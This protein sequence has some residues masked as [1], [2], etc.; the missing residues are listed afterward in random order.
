[1]DFFSYKLQK[2]NLVSYLIREQK[3]SLEEGSE[4]RLKYVF[5]AGNE[6]A[7]KSFKA[8]IFKKCG[9]KKHKNFSNSAPIYSMKIDL[10]ID[11]NS[12]SN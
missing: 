5:E 10:A 3:A 7:S 2:K 12:R 8:C 4:W 9:N 6:V 11:G 1:M